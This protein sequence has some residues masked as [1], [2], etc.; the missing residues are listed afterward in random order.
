MI[1]AVNHK[2]FLDLSI[3]CIKAKLFKKSVIIDVKSTFDKEI[4]NRN[5]YQ[6]W[7]L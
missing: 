2:Q 6:I 1:V 4:F 7:R 5:G 3:K